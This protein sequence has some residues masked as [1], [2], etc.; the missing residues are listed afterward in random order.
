MTASTQTDVRVSIEHNSRLV[1]IIDDMF[2]EI[3]STKNLYNQMI[4]KMRESF[5]LYCTEAL[6]LGYEPW[7]AF[8][9]IRKRLTGYISASTIYRWGSADLGPEAKLQ[10]GRQSSVAVDRSTNP[11]KKR[12]ELADAISV[13]SESASTAASTV[14]IIRLRDANSKN[15]DQYDNETCRR[16]L[17]DALELIEM[18]KRY[19]WRWQY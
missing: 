11:E 13:Y 16:L 8:E 19:G 4:V 2:L 9:Y 18:L 17:K 12:R 14:D 7:V 3:D 15:I 5:R 6:S 1:K 10:L